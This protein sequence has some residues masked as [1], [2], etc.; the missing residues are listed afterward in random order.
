MRTSRLLPA[1]TSFL[2]AACMSTTW[3]LIPVSPATAATPRPL[4]PGGEYVA[5]GSSFASGP[6]VPR[7][8]DPS[9]ARS[10]G[11]YAHLLAAALELQLEDVTCA[12]ATT[13]NLT[14]TPQTLL[15]GGQ[16][17]PQLDSVTAT[18]DLVTITIGGNDVNYI[19]DLWRNSC[20][21]PNN[22]PVPA[23]FAS[24]CAP[25]SP[26]A[27]QEALASVTA[28]LTS[29]VLA[30]KSKA[31]EA[32]VVLVDYLT[33][34]PQNAEPCAALPLSSEQI[35]YSLDVA[36]RLQLATKHAAQRAGAE[37]VELSKASRGHGVCS[38]DPW[39]TGWG[40]SP[41]FLVGGTVP[42]HPNA[43]GMSAAADL[44]AEHLR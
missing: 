23:V 44:L 13:A 19:G 42:Y 7:T 21:A 28:K 43:A 3:A 9:C 33:L 18:T 39:V 5:L 6:G 32:R 2:A 22:A 37:L 8:I 17:P 25:P 15:L 26:G 34:L 16:R 4:A 24:L 31:P 27:T 10:S 11:N 41:D 12:S 29:T 35:K 38:D 36:R 20:S 40:F 1:L 30:V 14:D